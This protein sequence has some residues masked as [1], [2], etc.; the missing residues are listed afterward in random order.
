MAL[1]PGLVLEAPNDDRLA[2]L[3]GALDHAARS[4]GLS[5]AADG[6]DSAAQLEVVRRLGLPYAQGDAV[7]PAASVV[8]LAA[9]TVPLA[10]P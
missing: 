6:V 9:M 1:H 3:L 5:L 8:D 10:I 2:T 7:S 4:L